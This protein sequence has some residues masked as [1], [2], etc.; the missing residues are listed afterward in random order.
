MGTNTGLVGKSRFPVVC[1]EKDMQVLVVT[2]ALL[3][4]ENDTVAQCAYVQ[5]VSAHIASRHYT[6]II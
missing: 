3:T 6:I 1:L 4:Q 5:L 2:T